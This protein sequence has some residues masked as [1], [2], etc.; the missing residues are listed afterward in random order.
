MTAFSRK[1]RVGPTERSADF[2]L[3]YGEFVGSEQDRVTAIAPKD[4]W[5]QTV[6][7]EPGGIVLIGPDGGHGLARARSY[8]LLMLFDPPRALDIPEA[9]DIEQ[10]VMLHAVAMS[11]VGP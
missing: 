5:G 1:L 7:V 6:G 4:E 3:A 2:V 8:L 11:P 10:P 9:V